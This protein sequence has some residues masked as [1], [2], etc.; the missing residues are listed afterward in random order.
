MKTNI[1]YTFFILA[2]LISSCD[3][4][5][6]CSDFRVGTFKHLDEKDGMASDIVITRTEAYQIESSESSN[7]SDTFEIEWTSDCEYYLVYESSSNPTRMAHSKFDTVFTRIL[8]PKANGYV[9]ESIFL[10]NRPQGELI[11]VE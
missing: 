7:Y 8:E 1:L 10:D 3:S 11:F 2:F 6:K 5:K 4:P 9:F